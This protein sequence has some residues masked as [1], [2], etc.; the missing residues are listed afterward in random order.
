[1]DIISYNQTPIKQIILNGITTI[2]ADFKMMEEKA[3]Q[4]ILVRSTEHSALPFY[5]ALRASL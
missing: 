5:L 2:S 3:A 4:I 1:V